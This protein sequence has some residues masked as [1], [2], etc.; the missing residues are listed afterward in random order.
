M[1]CIIVNEVMIMHFKRL[2][3]LRQDNNLTQQNVADFLHCQREVYRRYEKGLREIPVSYVISLAQYYNV[4][5]DYLLGESD[6]RSRE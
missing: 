3:E 2:A 5:I 6:D 4:S 1:L